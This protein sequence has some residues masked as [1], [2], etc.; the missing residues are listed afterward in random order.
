MNGEVK[1]RDFGFC[2]QITESKISYFN[3]TAHTQ[4]DIV[5]FNVSVYNVAFVQEI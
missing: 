2:A 1:L 5:G 4:K 3:V